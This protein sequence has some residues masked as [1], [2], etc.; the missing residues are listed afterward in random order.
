MVDVNVGHTVACSIVY[1]DQNGNPMLTTPTPDAPPTWTNA[2][3]TVD[4]LVVGPGGNT[5]TVDAIAAGIDV[6][7]L[8]LAVAGVSFSA[9]LQVSVHTAPQVLTSVT[10]ASSVS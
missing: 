10:I 7:T 2:Q 4:T 8:N 3:P 9:T 6:V 1:L 5:C